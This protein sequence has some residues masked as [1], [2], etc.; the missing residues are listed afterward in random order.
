MIV[1]DPG[2]RDDRAGVGSTSIPALLLISLIMTVGVATQG[3]FNPLQEIAK[4]D[5]SLS[6]FQISLLQGI[7]AALP[8][9]LLSIPIGRLIDRTHRVRLMC[10]MALLWTAG[11]LLTAFAHD[12]ALL[13]VAR[14]LAAIGVFGGL[15]VS[16]SI[17]ADLSAQDQR[18]RAM[19]LMSVGRIIGSALAFALGGVL[20]GA[21]ANHPLAMLDGMLPWRSVH[22]IFAAVGLVLI[23]PLLFFS[24]PVRHELGGVINPSA[25]EA[26]R[27]VWQRRGLLA[28]LFLGQ[29]MVTMADAAAAIWASPVLVRDYHQQPDQFGPWMGL[30][31]L[32]SGIVGSVLGG[33]L[34]D[35]GHKGRIR[36]GI[37]VGAVFASI[38][39]IP[40]AFFPIMPSVTGFA[41]ML[42]VL[43]IGGAITGLVTATALTVLVPNELRGV[44]LG[45]FMVVGALFGLGVAPTLVTLISD[46][47]GGEAH[48][49]QALTLIGVVAGLI[50]TVGFIG[51]MKSPEAAA[52]VPA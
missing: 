47:L 27:A 20:V 49:G 16:I 28:P 51:A 26:A 9:A 31:I 44:C 12:F 13:F 40:A 48:V 17:A 22:V 34:A 42:T 46:Q 37:L 2:T 52:P 50:S 41:L 21:L 24:E 10:V 33:V 45:A 1:P 11:T 18:G 5:M 8:V 7:A 32:S 29:V 35:Y 6:D 14:A 38:V 30:V 3:V 43:L 25:G 19:L 23:L 39:S 4:G 15:P 36:G